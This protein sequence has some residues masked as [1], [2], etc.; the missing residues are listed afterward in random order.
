M[1][2]Y[3]WSWDFLAECAANYT[4]ND[5]PQR[6]E[7]QEI[8]KQWNIDDFDFYMNFSDWFFCRRMA[9]QEIAQRRDEAT[10]AAA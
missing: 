3:Y 8:A 4:M 6:I 10:I 9:D 2:D 5:F 7:I 1:I